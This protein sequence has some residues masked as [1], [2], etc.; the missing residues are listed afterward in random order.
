V[1][2]AVGAALEAMIYAV[3]GFC[4]L[5]LRRSEPDVPRPFRVRALSVLGPLGI[6]LF[7][8][9]AVL[10]SVSVQDAFNPA[11]LVIILV[12]AG[13][14]AF[15]VLRVLPGIRAKEAARRTARPRRRPVP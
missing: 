11:P 6:G 9:L 4:T 2:V 10:A 8:V 5:R 3:A 12:A 14:S 1:L 13:L 15:Y 7:G